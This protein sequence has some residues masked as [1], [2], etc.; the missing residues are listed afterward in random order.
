MPTPR[1]VLIH[2]SRFWLLRETRE[3]CVFETETAEIVHLDWSM[4]GDLYSAGLLIL[5]PTERVQPVE[6]ER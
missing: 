3:G 5:D 2:G 1:K 6:G 4:V